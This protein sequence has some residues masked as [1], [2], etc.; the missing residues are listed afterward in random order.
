MKIF[1]YANISIP[2]KPNSRYPL[3]KFHQLK[4][5]VIEA[6][7]AQNGNLVEGQSVSEEILML[8]H[9]KDYVQGMK[10]GDV[11][12]K[13]MREMG[14]HWS[15]ALNER[16][17]RIVGCTLGATQSALQ[18][19]ISVVLGGGAHH[20]RKYGGRG[21]CVFN[22]V[23]IAAIDLL[24]SPA[25]SKIAVLDCDVHQGDGNSDILKDFSEIITV[26]IHGEKNYPFRKL[27]LND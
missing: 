23:A 25:I 27:F 19:G 10:S 17:S 4:E 8:A 21:F 7:L 5:G 3:D 16:G 13:Q 6:G 18:D 1:H 22:D 9:S 2:L 14:F 26:S 15:E 20:A 11:S 24:Q 12:D